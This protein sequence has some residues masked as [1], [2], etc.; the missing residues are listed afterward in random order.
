M[1]RSTYRLRL[2]SDPSKIIPALWMVGLRSRPRW[3]PA[4]ALLGI[5]A[6]RRTPAASCGRTPEAAWVIERRDLLNRAMYVQ[7]KPWEGP[8]EQEQPVREEPYIVDPLLEAM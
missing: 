3:N 1:S 7:G 2:L 5:S 4:L 8:P 6:R